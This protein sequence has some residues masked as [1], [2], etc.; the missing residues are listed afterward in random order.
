M[1]VK[2]LTVLGDNQQRCSGAGS[3]RPRAVGFMAEKASRHL[4]SRRWNPVACLTSQLLSFC[5]AASAG[6]SKG[7]QRFSR[8]ARKYGLE[9]KA[10]SP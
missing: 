4:T 8:G 1:A 5:L 3:G 9:I 7:Q 10:T 2:V 6:P